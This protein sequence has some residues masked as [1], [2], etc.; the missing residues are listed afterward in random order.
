MEMY[1]LSLKS[2]VLRFRFF[3]VRMP[4]PPKKKIGLPLSLLGQVCKGGVEASAE[5]RPGALHLP[6][7]LQPLLQ[8]LH[9]P[10]HHVQRGKE[11]TAAGSG[12]A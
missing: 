8:G 11:A 3:F 5:Q 7:E 6:G 10:P 2:S 4:P 1:S 12:S 9:R